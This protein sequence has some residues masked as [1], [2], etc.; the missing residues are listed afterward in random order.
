[1]GGRSQGGESSEPDGTISNPTSM[2]GCAINLSEMYR[3]DKRSV[4]LRI[5][6]PI[7]SQRPPRAATAAASATSSSVSPF[8]ISQTQ[9]SVGISVVFPR[10]VDIETWRMLGVGV[11]FPAWIS[12]MISCC[13]CS[14]ESLRPA[15]PLNLTMRRGRGG[16]GDR[17]S[18]V[19]GSAV[20]NTVDYDSKWQI[21]S[22]DGRD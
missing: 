10:D 4:T 12:S 18:V 1:M 21:G 9:L 11:E 22:Y 2:T 19:S 7:D 5:D 3:L 6:G 16:R 14:F 13:K 17:Q 15:P 8:L 20:W